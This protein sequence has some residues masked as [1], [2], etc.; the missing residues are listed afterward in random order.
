[1][2]TVVAIG[3]ED[4][5]DVASPGVL[6]C[7][8]PAEA[9]TAT[10]AASISWISVRSEHWP[11]A[12]PP[13]APPGWNAFEPVLGVACLVF[14]VGVSGSGWVARLAHS[15][16]FAGLEPR[17]EDLTGV[18]GEPAGCWR[19]PES[20]A[21]TGRD[22]AGAALAF[23][24][25]GSIPNVPLATVAVMPDAKQGDHAAALGLVAALRERRCG[26]GCRTAVVVTVEGSASPALLA[27]VRGLRGL[28]AF[29]V[30]PGMAAGGDHLH[31]FPL[32][33]PMTPRGGRLVCVDLA[34]HLACWPPGG[35]AALHVIPSAYDAAEQVFRRLADAGHAGSHGARA[36][37][38]HM[39]LHADAPGSRLVKIDRLAT[40]CGAFLLAPDGNMVFTDTERLDGT[41]ATADL[42]IV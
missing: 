14:G 33:A 16:W 31:H 19:L 40:L 15:G 18:D 26:R 17:P 28:G 25:H 27:L 12:I 21:E 29:V 35:V 5:F 2:D 23:F 8:C 3:L 41:T 13:D 32:R 36:I 7:P 37:N 1:M 9:K 6:A 10:T 34:D 11:A 38:L 30:R 20:C 4:G 42:L 22:V 39:H 24:E